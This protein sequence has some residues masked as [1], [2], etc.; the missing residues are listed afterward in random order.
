M[1]MHSTYNRTLS[2]L[3]RL[4][5]V[6]A[7]ILCSAYGLGAAKSYAAS[8]YTVEDI[9]VDVTDE[10]ALTARDKA[11]KLAQEQAY[12]KLAQRLTEEQREAAK[13]NMPDEMTLAAM[14]RDYEI[15]SEKLSSVRYVG[16]YTIR[17]K[18]SEVQRFFKQ[19]DQSFTDEQSPPI[20]IL[21]YMKTDAGYEIWEGA[22]DWTRAWNK[23]AGTR[24]LVP[25]VTALGDLKAMQAVHGGTTI[26]YDPRALTDLIADYNATEA[27]I[28]VAIPDGGLK[29]IASP[30]DTAHGALRVELYKTYGPKPVLA[31]QLFVAAQDG[32]SRADLY[33]QASSRVH[34]MLSEN[35]KAQRLAGAQRSMHVRATVL[36]NNLPDWMRIK[37]I[38]DRNDQVSGL[39][40]EG[41]SPGQAVVS[42]TLKRGVPSF[43]RAMQRYNLYIDDK[44][45]QYILRPM[46]APS[47]SF[48]QPEAGDA[49]QEALQKPE[50][51]SA[52]KVNAKQL[53]WGG[54]PVY[55][56]TF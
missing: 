38:L 46:P 25:L 22:N 24:G 33:L 48:V 6:F 45:G 23:Q 29:N 11:F 3:A 54:Q 56:Q 39:Q 44:Q 50:D 52:V 26:E 49:A 21:P 31:S 55:R 16:V 1:I 9:Q 30:Q 42:M 7:L 47:P 41:L 10:N 36:I 13:N 27:V 2:G 20:L 32:I 8:V 5:A 14:I 17:F 53:S 37:N 12:I 34:N 18:E 40:V 15:T 35:W 51:Q 28:A 4:F 43:N 19:T